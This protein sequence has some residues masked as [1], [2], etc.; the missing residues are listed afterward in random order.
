[1]I[2][3]WPTKSPFEWDRFSSLYPHRDEAVI[4]GKSIWGSFVDEDGTGGD[5]GPASTI[6]FDGAHIT[7]IIGF[8]GTF[9]SRQTYSVSFEWLEGS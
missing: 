5:G 1:M 6:R 8:H 3:V 9:I 7:C 4:V 2:T